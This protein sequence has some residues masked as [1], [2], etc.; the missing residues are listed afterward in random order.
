MLG[1]FLGR[2]AR[3]RGAFLAVS[4]GSVRGNIRPVATAKNPNLNYNS[5][6]VVSAAPVE[7][8]STF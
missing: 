3:N 4:A 6:R 5:E 7:D 1:E 2:L 8:D